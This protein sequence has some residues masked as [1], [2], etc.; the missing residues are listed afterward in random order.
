MPPEKSNIHDVAR[1]ARVSS[2]T[3][4]RVLAG[5]ESVNAQLR[6]RV[7]DAVEELKYQPNRVAQSL[8]VQR[9]STIGLIMPDIQNALFVSLV[10]A[11]EDFAYAHQLTVILCNTDDKPEKERS[12]LDI[13]RA[14]QAAG[15]IVVPTHHGDADALPSVQA[16]GTPVVLVDREIAGFDA[17][18]VLVDN[19][20]GARLGVGHLIEEGY[21]RIAIIAGPQDLTPGRRRL[22]GYHSAHRDAGLQSQPELVKIGT[23][24]RDSG[25]QLTHELLDSPEPPD[26]IFASNNLMALGSLRALHERGVRI[27]DTVA[28]ISFDDMPWAEDLNPPLTVIA[29]P[30]YEMGQQAVE[31]LLQRIRYPAASYRTVILQ[32]QLIIRQSSSKS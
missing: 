15:L 21:Q 16:S 32:P 2:A 27:P 1:K 10:R 30:S 17:D 6:E 9:S 18:T 3:V 24:K 20:G 23:F 26:A 25:Y 31:S 19:V 7:L 4:S 8:R 12:Y 5:N 13:M 28:L 14:Q 22:Q 11:V 29:Q